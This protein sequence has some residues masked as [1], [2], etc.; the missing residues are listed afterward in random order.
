MRRKSFLR[1]M[2]V[3]SATALLTTGCLQ[4]GDDGGGGGGGSE[5]TEEGDGSVQILGAF[6]DPE[7]GFFEDS[8]KDFEK[9][10]GI[11]VTYVASTDFTTEIRTRVQGGNPPDI[12]LFPQ[13][14]LVEEL[15]AGADAIPLNDLVDVDKL[16]E[17]LIPGFLDSVTDENGN[18]FAAPMRM[19]VKSIVW[20]PKPAFEEAGYEVPETWTDLQELAEQMQSDGN[21][22]WCLGAEAGADTGWVLTDWVEEMVLRT[23]G[24]DVYDEWVNHEIPFDDPQIQEAAALF[25]DD[26]LFKQGAVAGG[27]QGVLTTPFDVSPNGMFEDPP[28]CFLHRQGNFVTGFFPKDVQ[29]NLAEE[30]GTFVLPPVED[31]YDGTP[32]LGGGDMATAFV[33]D[34]DVV[35]VMKFITSDEFGKPWAAAG[36]WL[37]PHSTFDNSAYPDPT[38]QEIAALVQ[39]GDIFRFDASDLMPAEVGAGTFWDGMVDWA[40]EEKSLEEALASI[41]E[42]WPSD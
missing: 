9:E 27:P 14:G 36:G 30:V 35:E 12:G 8:L 39:Q 25:G 15:G 42:S 32:I 26:I 6:P 28:Q 1:V 29:S 13:P 5:E 4:G 16:N 10:S 33:N 2:A 23:A 17:T 22:P 3:T 18:L 19:A 7:A 37:S 11:D 38:T 40:A 41:E 34:T 24:P 21:T 31:G 20:Y